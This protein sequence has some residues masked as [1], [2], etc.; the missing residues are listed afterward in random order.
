METVPTPV[1]PV[2]KQTR[3]RVRRP[4]GGGGGKEQA[5]KVNGSEEKMLN[6]ARDGNSNLGAR[7]VI[8]LMG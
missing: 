4:G 8:L 6:V 3:Q 5:D 2:I 1:K 7:A